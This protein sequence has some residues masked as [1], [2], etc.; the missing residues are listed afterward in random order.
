MSSDAKHPFLA[1][2]N[3][4]QVCELVQ[5]AGALSKTND[6][7]ADLLSR[8]EGALDR[9]LGTHPQGIDKDAGAPIAK[10]HVATIKAE[11]AA[12]DAKSTCLSDL[13]SRLETLG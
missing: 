13:I 2:P 8:F 3:Q 7:Y 12:L 6:A 4:V 1:S 5:V 9:I 11:L 10:S